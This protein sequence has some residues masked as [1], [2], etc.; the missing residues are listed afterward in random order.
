M[1][2]FAKHLHRFLF[3]KGALEKDI[4]ALEERYYKKQLEVNEF[5]CVVN[6]FHCVFIQRMKDAEEVIGQLTRQV[7][8]LQESIR[9]LSRDYNNLVTLKNGFKK[10]LQDIDRLI[11]ELVALSSEISK[12]IAR[13]HELVPLKR[14]RPKQESS[15]EPGVKRKPGRPR[16][17]PEI[18]DAAA[19]SDC[20][21]ESTQGSP[22]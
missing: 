12:K 6:E 3:S 14:G 13:Y 11:H 16:K 17:N 21:P 7:D 5:H 18:L 19:Q 8:S 1:F 22:L 10:E 2:D 20:E 9:I 15:T 4:R